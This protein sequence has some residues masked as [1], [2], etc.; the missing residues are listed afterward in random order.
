MVAEVERVLITR[1]LKEA[2]G[3]K[4]AAAKVL[5]LTREGLHKKL[6]KLGIV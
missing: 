3:N 1:T 2:G 4:T 6:N 5:G